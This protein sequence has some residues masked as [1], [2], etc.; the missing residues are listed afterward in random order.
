MSYYTRRRFYN[1]SK[2]VIRVCLAA[3]A[4]YVALS[5][6][7][8]FIGD[9]EFANFQDKIFSYTL[10][11][12]IPFL[13][14]FGLA[15][16][17]LFREDEEELPPIY[18]YNQ[19][20]KASFKPLVATLLGVCL[21]IFA[22]YNFGFKGSA[23]APAKA[24]SNEGYVEA[25][26]SSDAQPDEVN[27]NQS[28]S[29]DALE[30]E[31]LAVNNTPGEPA[32]NGKA[33]D[34]K[35]QTNIEKP[36]EDPAV[37]NSNAAPQKAAPA[38]I[39]KK[40]VKKDSVIVL[41]KEEETEVDMKPATTSGRY[42]DYTSVETRYKVASKAYLYNSPDEGTRRNAFIN[43]NSS[44]A[45]LIPKGEKNG[46]IYVVFSNNKGQTTMGWLHKKDLRPV[47]EMVYNSGK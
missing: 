20:P 2:M 44:Y 40:E 30:P 14:L 26:H 5:L 12:L 28:I 31:K 45:S 17:Y 1:A 16:T 3:L 7:F 34:D 35:K 13:M 21:V 36:K 18:R 32:E 46:F 4:V 43:A 38:A 41:P 8:Y 9:S 22:I 11:Y 47:S 23:T 24:T 33:T 42:T 29:E 39:E 10:V 27:G 6:V 15:G 25:I 19:R 37:V